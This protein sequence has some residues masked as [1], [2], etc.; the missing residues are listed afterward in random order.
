VKDGEE[1]KTEFQAFST[2]SPIR[3]NDY[4]EGYGGGGGCTLI[5]YTQRLALANW[6]K[7]AC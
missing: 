1:D 2:V 5:Q 4:E 3:A 7:G 6:G